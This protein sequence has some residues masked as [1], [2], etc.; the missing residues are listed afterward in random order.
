[1]SWSL[2][3]I[4]QLGVTA[5][6]IV[7]AF[8]LRNRQLNKHL[9][10]MELSHDDAGTA[11]EEAKDKLESIED[12]KVWLKTRIAEL[13]DDAPTTVVQRMVLQNESKA[14]KSFVEDLSALLGGA[15][16]SDSWR[17]VRTR[18]HELA[19]TLIQQIPWKQP[20][21]V[22]LY[23]LFSPLDEAFEFDLPALPEA[24]EGSS[25][26]TD[27][28]HL[29]KANEQLQEELNS[30]RAALLTANSGEGDEEHDGED[31]KILLQQF[32]RDSR[33][34][35][36]CIQMLEGE[37][38]Q[39]RDRMASLTPDGSEDASTPAE[40]AEVSEGDDPP[41][42]DQSDIDAIMAA[43]ESS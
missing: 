7:A 12:R 29:R 4:V 2:F 32:T 15:D 35:M 41:G 22:E 6:G 42:V 37:N 18:Q 19:T 36:I 40:P 14:K 24:E 10:A 5:A 13:K 27:D 25:D 9:A 23:E 21:I 16:V 31:L 8:W 33:D 30:A 38:Q 39:L 3:A 43:H 11:L 1:M 26:Q 17:D 28:D 20:A 34:M